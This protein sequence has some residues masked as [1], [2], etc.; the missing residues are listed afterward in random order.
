MPIICQL[1]CCPLHIT[2]HLTLFSWS[3]YGPPGGFFDG[4]TSQ[5]QRR[6]FL[7]SILQGAGPSASTSAA[8]LTHQQLNRLLARGP[9]E[10]ELL[11]SKAAAWAGAAAGGGGDPA[12]A[13]SG[14]AHAA[15]GDGAGAGGEASSDG[16]AVSGEYHL[17]AIAS[18]SRTWQCD[19]ASIFLNGSSRSLQYWEASTLPS[20]LAACKA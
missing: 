8:T 20:V 16:D 12:V 17:N 19:Q 7:L 5:E 6:E 11:D 15:G 14:P 4:K 9:E 10:V 3:F 18:I 13:S 2:P 1:A